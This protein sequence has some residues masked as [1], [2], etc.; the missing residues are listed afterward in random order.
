MVRITTAS[1]NANCSVINQEKLLKN[2]LQIA[3]TANKH[4]SITSK[5]KA[6]TAGENC[7]ITSLIIKWFKFKLIC[8]KRL[9]FIVKVKAIKHI[10]LI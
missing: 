6:K 3:V 4:N 9:M 1:N 2:V 10:R 8:V 7:Y 5:S